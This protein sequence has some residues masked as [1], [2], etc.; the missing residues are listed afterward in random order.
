M[1]FI[2]QF[3]NVVYHI[4][5]LVDIKES[6]HSWDKAH[7]DQAFLKHDYTS[8]DEDKHTH[9]HTHTHCIFFVHLFINAHFGYFHTLAIVNNAAM[10]IGVY[11]SFQINFVFFL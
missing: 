4:D 7:F 10:N 9:T 8:Q 5:W 6:L 1:V 11:I 3:V 2:F